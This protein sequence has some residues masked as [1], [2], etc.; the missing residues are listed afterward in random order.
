ML[1]GEE[2]MFPVKHDNAPCYKCRWFVNDWCL[3]EV[4]DRFPSPLY[5]GADCSEFE[6]GEKVEVIILSGSIVLPDKV[7]KEI[8][9]KIPKGEY[10][11]PKIIKKAWKKYLGER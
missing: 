1:R 2:K 5:A 6:E 10:D 3:L 11:V 7:H 9:K 8:M 4:L